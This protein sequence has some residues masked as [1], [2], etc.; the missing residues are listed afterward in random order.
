MLLNLLQ[1][2]VGLVGLV[3]GGNLLVSGSSR[4]AA[5]FGVTPLIIG[6]TIVAFG[7]STPELLVN[8]SAALNGVSDIAIGNIVGS[9][10]A[11][12]GLILGISGLLTPIAIHTGLLRREIPVM[13]GASVLTFILALDGEIGRMDGLILVLGFIAFNVLMVRLTLASRDENPPLDKEHAPKVNRLLELG[14]LVGGLALLVLG[15]NFTVNGAVGIARTVGVSELVIGL[16]IV[17]VGTSLPELFTSVIAAMRKENDISVGN[18]VGS[19]I[20]NL[21]LIL[22]IVAVFQPITVAPRAVEF[23]FPIMLVYALLLLPFA[24]T[25]RV[26][27]RREAALFLIGYAAFIAFS[28]LA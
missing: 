28:F 20:F 15:A 18:V 22:G 12:I 5:S 2:V 21:L 6:L 27:T 25:G 14:R 19:N 10:I 1:L 3:A 9:N 11:N 24:W 26:L 4:L 7:T 8:I 13:I 23:D 16:S 17:A